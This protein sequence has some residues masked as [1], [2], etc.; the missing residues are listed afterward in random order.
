MVKSNRI[1]DNHVTLYQTPDGKVNIEVMYADE[2][3]WLTQKRMAELFG[4]DR[5]VVTKHLK[6]IFISKELL[7]DSVCANYAHTADDG[8]LYQTKFYS[9]EAIVAVGYRV[10]SELG[11]Q[12]R[13]WAISILKNYIH[14]GFAIDSDRCYSKCNNLLS[15]SGQ[16]MCVIRTSS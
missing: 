7:E 2:N 12:F 14:K 4:V 8:K 13:Q 10:N 15:L 9:L 16:V 3:M 5:S 6:N 11:T 1:P